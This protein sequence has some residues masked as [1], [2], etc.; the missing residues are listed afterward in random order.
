MAIADDAMYRRQSEILAEMLAALQAAVADAY[1]GDDG[2]IS[3]VFRI[4][5]GQLEN[6]YL[7]NQLL[8]EDSFVSSATFQAL[9]RHGEQYGLAMQDGTVSI[10]SLVFSGGGGTYVPI[11]TEVAYDPG[12]GL[13]P[14]YFDTTSDGT[15]PNPGT[16]TPP[17]AAVNVTAGN[18]NGLYE[19]LVTF[20]TAS[21]E[22]VPSAESNAVSPVSQ[23]VNLTAIPIGGPGTTARR[24]YRSLNGSGVYRRITEIANNTAT[25]FTDNVTD[26][27][28]NAGSLVPTVDSA[29]SITVTAQAQVSGV[30]GNVA[31]GAITELTN[32]PA[33]LTD[34]I[35]ISAFSGGSDPEDTEDFRTRVLNAIQNPQTGSPSDLKA[36][37][38]NID[39]VGTATVFPGV[40]TAGQVTVRITSENGG[41]PDAALIAEV[42]SELNIK[43]LANITV[44]VASF[45]QSTA[46]VTVDVTTSG[47][48]TLAD[49]TP[50]VQQ[51]ITDYI[52]SLD[53]GETL[54]VAGIIDAVFG[55][56]GI[57]DVVVTTP[58]TNQTIASDHKWVP[59]TITAT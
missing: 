39:G 59:G 56:A 31:A 3:I 17:T 15:I 27:V 43:D 9:R 35:N 10:G 38:E 18:L 21:G 28:M 46:N 20:V 7:A 13:D 32:A 52:N 50:Q 14:V 42:Q 55:L 49:V 6:L 19:Y 1:V 47:T 48:Y 26:A 12:A 8:L 29:L 22:T 54:M 33:T 44:I 36:W 45:V 2:A 25:T 41:I 23:Q 37:S 5:A 34:V 53:I 58:V 11:G 57:A 40:P 30:E 51:S 24:I 4:E 16:P